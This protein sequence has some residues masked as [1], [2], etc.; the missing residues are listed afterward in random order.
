ML[1]SFHEDEP[2]EQKKPI[3]VG[4]QPFSQGAVKIENILNTY[5]LKFRTP[6]QLEIGK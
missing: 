4:R 6:F 1:N 3:E 2:G 5:R